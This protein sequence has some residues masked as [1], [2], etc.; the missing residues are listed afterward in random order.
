MEK[1]ADCQC[2]SLTTRSRS[3]HEKLTPKP[4]T[5]EIPNDSS[6]VMGRTPA[7][8]QGW[9]NLEQSVPGEL[10]AQKVLEPIWNQDLK[11]HGPEG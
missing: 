6:D 7:N 1:R 11:Q 2:P 5:N 3:P 9:S 4:E 8:A 10:Q